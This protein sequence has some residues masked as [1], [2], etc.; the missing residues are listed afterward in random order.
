MTFSINETP[1]KEV[2]CDTQHKQH[3]AYQRSLGYSECR[4]ADCHVLV[5]VMQNDIMVIVVILYVI[6]LS[7]MAPKSHRQIILKM[8]NSDESKTAL[9][10]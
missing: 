4:Y 2:I 6:T 3:R 10:I 5:I 8:F 9:A 7:V 1:H